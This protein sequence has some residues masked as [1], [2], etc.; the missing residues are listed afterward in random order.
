M[1]GRGGK[2]LCI[3]SLPLDPCPLSVVDERVQS[4]GRG[5]SV[6]TGPLDRQ[7]PGD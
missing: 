1:T 5:P 7:E 4:A 2:P 6:R 3:H